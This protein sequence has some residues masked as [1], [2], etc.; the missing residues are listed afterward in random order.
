VFGIPEW[1]VGI[2]FVV[3]ALS[4]VKGLVRGLTPLDRGRRRLSGLGLGTDL[5]DVQRRLGELEERQRQLGAGEDMQ[6]RLGELEE[7]LDFV[8]RMLAKQR[9]AERIVPPRS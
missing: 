4:L 7:R 6:T 1:A 9:D 8:E 3:A 2:V 5:E